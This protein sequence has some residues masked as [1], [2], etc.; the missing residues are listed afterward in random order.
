MSTHSIPQNPA[1]EPAFPRRGE[2]DGMGQMS[3]SELELFQ[4][5]AEEREAD[6][7]EFD[8]VAEG[9]GGEQDDYLEIDGHQFPLN[10][11]VDAAVGSGED[12]DAGVPVHGG[13]GDHQ[14]EDVSE[15]KVVP[16]PV[17]KEIDWEKEVA[18]IPDDDIEDGVNRG[19]RKGKYSRHEQSLISAIRVIQEIKTKGSSNVPILLNDLK[20][21]CGLSDYE[22]NNGLGD[23]VGGRGLK[24]A[25]RG[26]K[27]DR[28]LENEMRCKRYIRDKITPSEVASIAD[29]FDDPDV[30][31]KIIS[32]ALR[33][34][35]PKG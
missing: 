12:D 8:E 30:A 9:D 23:A 18:S 13:R 7:A 24:L 11:G 34:S 25:R 5:E 2:N 35:P 10:D 1:E 17:A 4:L 32:G 27:I 15:S 6:P 26:T 19:G 22:N 29:E 14:G 21:G 28:S 31:A 33:G 3:D 20:V 16:D